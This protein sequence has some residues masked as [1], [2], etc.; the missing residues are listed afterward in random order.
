MADY[1]EITCIKVQGQKLQQHEF[2]LIR[3][4]I[5]KKFHVNGHIAITD[6]GMYLVFT[7]QD[8]DR[9]EPTAKGIKDMLGQLWNVSLTGYTMVLHKGNV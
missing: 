2:R 7:T 8:D 1:N 9:P 6:K 4:T 5:I 3:D